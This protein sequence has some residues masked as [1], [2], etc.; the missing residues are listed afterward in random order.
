MRIVELT[1]TQFDEYA[2]FH[3]LN[4]YC[5]NSKYAL[6]M[7]DYGYSYDYIGFIDDQSNI[8]AAALILTKKIKGKTKYGY[9]PK[10]FLINYYDQA[11]LSD[12]LNQIRKY[13][14]SKDFIF[15]K[16]NPEI[17]IGEADKK[18]DYVFNYN[19]NVRIIDDLKSLNVKRRLELKEFDLM[20]PKFNTY[21]NLKRFDLNNIERTHRKKIK[22]CI[23]R[24][25]YLT[26]GGPKDIETLY[27]FNK[28]KSI[29]PLSYLRNMFNVYN[30]DNSIDLVFIKLDFQKYLSYV[31]IRFD[32]EQA[33]NDKWNEIIQRE[34]KKKHINR[35]ISSDMKLQ[36]LKDEI[37]FATNGLKKHPQV[38]VAG[39][40]IV[41]HFNKVSII[42]SGFSKE[43]GKLDPNHYLYYAIME[44]Y[45]PYFNFLDMNG[46]SGNFEN[47]SKYDGL[48]DFKLKYNPDVYEFVGEFDLICADHTFKKL[49]KTS[50]IEDEFSK[51]DDEEKK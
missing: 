47:T 24:G 36:S 51:E 7:S 23:H 18:N 40:L 31:R 43:F 48:N 14:K 34:P 44:R 22:K 28:G 6:V 42:E 8:K 35:K 5:Q 46:I 45:K 50:F 19:G 17:I 41:K 2:R 4:N 1:N 39:A 27:N 15:I 37:I 38:I 11:L 29:R 10:G 16:F 49:I 21:I 25:M 13:Y 12:F 20:M 32:E 3:P 9:A 26:L 30:K 33:I